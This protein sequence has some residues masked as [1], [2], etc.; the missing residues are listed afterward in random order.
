MFTL[1]RTLTTLCPNCFWKHSVQCSGI[2]ILQCC[3]LLIHHGPFMNTPSH[4]S[5]TILRV[6]Y[7]QYKHECE[8]LLK[9]LMSKHRWVTY[10]AVIFW[11]MPN[12]PYLVLFV[13]YTFLWHSRKVSAGDALLTNTTSL[14]T[15][16]PFNTSLP[17]LV[18]YFMLSPFSALYKLNV[19][20]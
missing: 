11:L 9:T 1:Y 3:L 2:F 18:Q 12:Y 17:L 4:S 13:V 10:S 19:T 16:T 5:T 7:L 8:P 20:F 6:I 14:K 15:N